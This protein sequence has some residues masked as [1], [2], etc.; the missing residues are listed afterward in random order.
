[1]SDNQEQ[2][3][4][5]QHNRINEILL[6][7][8]IMLPGQD[9]RLLQR[10]GYRS[11]LVKEAGAGGKKFTFSAKIAEIN[12]FEVSAG[13]SEKVL[14]VEVIM[15]TSNHTGSRQF[16]KMRLCEAS[17]TVDYVFNPPFEREMLNS[18]SSSTFMIFEK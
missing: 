13:D 17:N 10:S 3:L 9:N 18:I 6:W 5:I 12:S 7:A 2:E 8:K 1:M 11:V 14:M 15:A 4:E 16:V